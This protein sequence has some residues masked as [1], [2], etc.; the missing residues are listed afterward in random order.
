MTKGAKNVNAT[1]ECLLKATTKVASD[2]ELT[3]ESKLMREI[4][5][6][7]NWIE[8]VCESEGTQDDDPAVAGSKSA[9]SS[10]S[11]ATPAV[12]VIQFDEASGQALNQQPQPQPEDTSTK[13]SKT[14]PPVLEQVVPWKAWQHVYAEPACDTAS[15]KAS[16]VAVLHTL[17][18][19]CD[20]GSLPVEVCDRQGKT[21]VRATTRIEQGKLM[22]PPSVANSCSMACTPQRHWGLNSVEVL[23][24]DR[25][26]PSKF[27]SESHASEDQLPATAEEKKGDKKEVEKR[28]KKKRKEGEKKAT[29]EEELPELEETPAITFVLAPEW[30]MPALKPAIEKETHTSDT[31]EGTTLCPPTSSQ[32][33]NVTRSIDDY[34]WTEP[35][36]TTPKA[37]RTHAALSPY[38]GVRRMSA[39]ALKER[40]ATYPATGRKGQFNCSLQYVKMTNVCVGVANGQAV[41]STRV[42]QVP[43][44]TNHVAVEAGEELLLEKPENEPRAKPHVQKHKSQWKT[45]PGK[46]KRGRVE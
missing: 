20:V 36:S 28:E 18:G 42:V 14:V 39:N 22:V 35:R 2:L 29:A 31:I 37:C 26:L 34:M 45:P 17:A 10:D 38:W 25:L 9:A 7:P 16:A 12:Q 24:R 27:L 1:R 21:Y 13:K 41:N 43:F 15:A 4:T 44:L 46:N 32:V 30:K 6:K 8:F 3:G 23:V 19:Q 40:N 5:D 11:K 33:R